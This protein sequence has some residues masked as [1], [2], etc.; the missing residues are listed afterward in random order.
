MGGEEDVVD[1]V[2]DGV[3]AGSAGDGDD[4]EIFGGVAVIDGGSLGFGFLEF[5]FE[6]R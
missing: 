5:W 2:G 3:F 4:A 1:K 6:A